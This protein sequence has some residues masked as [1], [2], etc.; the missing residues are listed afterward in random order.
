MGFK[1]STLAVGPTQ[2]SVRAYRELFPRR[3]SCR[4]FN[5]TT[6]LT[7]WSIGPAAIDYYSMP[8]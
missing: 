4:I 8:D 3:Q 6:Y 5:L 2:R 1:A 7:A